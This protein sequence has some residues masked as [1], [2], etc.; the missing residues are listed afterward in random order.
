M[1]GELSDEGRKEMSQSDLRKL[2]GR[3]FDHSLKKSKKRQHEVGTIIS[4]ISSKEQ[5]QS[6]R[7]SPSV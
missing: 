2:R 5:I 6:S 1:L 7:H 3:K 4:T